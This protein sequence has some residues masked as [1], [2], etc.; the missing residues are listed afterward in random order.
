MT[1]TTVPLLQVVILIDNNGFMQ[2]F[3]T[4]YMHAWSVLC[5]VNGTI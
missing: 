2:S 4:A 5:L 1:P 3:V